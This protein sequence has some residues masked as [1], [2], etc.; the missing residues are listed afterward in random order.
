MRALSGS[1]AILSHAE[2]H[3]GTVTFLQKKSP[4]DVGT[5]SKINLVQICF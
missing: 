3:V 4:T 2:R 5:N 1:I